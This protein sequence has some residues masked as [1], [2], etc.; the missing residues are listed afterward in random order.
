MTRAIVITV[1]LGAFGAGC[2]EVYEDC[3]PERAPADFPGPADPAAQCAAVCAHFDSIGCGL[4]CPFLPDGGIDAGTQIVQ[5]D[6]QAT[7]LTALTTPS[8][9]SAESLD[10]TLRCY[11]GTDSCTQVGACSRLCGDTGGITWPVDLICTGA[12]AGP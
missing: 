1:L 6:C 3:R 10:R 5:L 7:C 12:D 9:A 2:E 4:G 8:G 11:A